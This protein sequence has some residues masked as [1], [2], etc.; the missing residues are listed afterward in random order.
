MTFKRPTRLSKNQTKGIEPD[1]QKQDGV[2]QAS[3]RVD[4]A[5]NMNESERSPLY[6]HFGF[7][8]QGEAII[9]RYNSF[10]LSIYERNLKNK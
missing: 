4:F 7:G 8:A 1:S 10:H 3:Q 5:N 2:R 6:I 9:V